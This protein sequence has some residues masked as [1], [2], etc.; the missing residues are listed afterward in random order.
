MSKTDQ[1]I[2]ILKSHSIDP[3]NPYGYVTGYL[4]GVLKEFE[5]E[6]KSA[7]VILNEHINHLLS[8]EVA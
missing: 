3:N 1:L 4:Q 6:Y 2:A 8:K 7:E 5:N